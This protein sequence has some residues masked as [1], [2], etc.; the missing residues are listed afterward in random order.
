MNLK[1]FL[2]GDFLLPNHPMKAKSG[3]PKNAA[4]DSVPD[5]FNWAVVV[6]LVM[7]IGTGVDPTDV[8]GVLGPEQA[9]SP[10]LENGLPVGTPFVSSMTLP[11]AKELSVSPE[12]E[13]DVLNTALS[14]PVAPCARVSEVD[15][16]T[17]WTTTGGVGVD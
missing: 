1:K 5:S 2:R 7:V 4:R 12:G 11:H 15:S 9:R 3:T 16:L 10:V 8:T 17:T 14:T 6:E 13:A